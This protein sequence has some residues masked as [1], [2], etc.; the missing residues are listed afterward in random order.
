MWRRHGSVSYSS[1]TR[2][3]LA[4]RENISASKITRY[5]VVH[6]CAQCIRIQDD[7]YCNSSDDE[8]LGMMDEFA[9]MAPRSLATAGFVESSGKKGR[10]SP[11]PALEVA[12][13]KVR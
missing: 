9:A 1:R 13:A 7:S 3:E 5:T 4:V 11:P 8:E 2:I 12:V 10:S 6:L